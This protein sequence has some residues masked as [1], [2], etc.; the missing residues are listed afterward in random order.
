VVAEWVVWAVHHAMVA[1]YKLM[2][3]N[4]GCWSCLGWTGKF[5]G[6]PRLKVGCRRL[7]AMWTGEMGRA[8]LEV[9]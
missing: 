9:S 4:L 6:L 8:W 3:V 2:L 7:A 1:G 5:A